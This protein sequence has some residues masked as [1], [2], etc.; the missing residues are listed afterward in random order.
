MW[1]GIGV[2]I[3]MTLSLLAFALAQPALL[4]SIADPFV[5]LLAGEIWDVVVR[6]LYIQTIVVLV[7]GLLFVA[8]A[9]LAGPSPRAV[10]IRTGVH[11]GWDRLWKR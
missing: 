8:G 10:A 7:V 6:G 3:T 5:R 9:A 1:I 2:A 11:N 4:V